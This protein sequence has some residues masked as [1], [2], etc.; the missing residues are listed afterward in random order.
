MI[1]S[2]KT[3]YKINKPAIL[4]TSTSS[5]NTKHLRIKSSNDIFSKAKLSLRLKQEFK[6]SRNP[7]ERR[8]TTTL[9]I[10][11]KLS[12]VI[13]SHNKV[14]R[15]TS[16]LP[17]KHKHPPSYIIPSIY[18]RSPS[19]IYRLNTITKELSNILRKLDNKPLLSQP[20]QT[21]KVN[22]TP[23]LI[24]S[25]KS[26]NIPNRNNIQKYPT[27]DFTIKRPFL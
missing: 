19:P 9:T 13:S 23:R 2:F 25:S 10:T 4:R 15:S 5:F 22:R 14:S 3:P 16:T 6:N 21:I 20:N 12:N 1:P 7:Q 17:I 26:R 8:T 27:L 18:L 24:S 11:S